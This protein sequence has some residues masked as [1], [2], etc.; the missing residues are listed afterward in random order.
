MNDQGLTEWVVK[1][2][3]GAGF[4]RSRA[5]Q[6]PIRGT[7]RFAACSRRSRRLRS[8]SASFVLPRAI[9]VLLLLLMAFVENRFRNDSSPREYRSGARGFAHL[10]TQRAQSIEGLKLQPFFHNSGGA[11]RTHHRSR[12]HSLFDKG[13]HAP[14]VLDFSP[15]RDDIQSFQSPEGHRISAWSKIKSSFRKKS[16]PRKTMR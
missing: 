10:S 16:W 7:C 4:S 12:S 11:I 8:C 14:L 5:P 15:G 3:V 1:P 9:V 13:H 2:T 6:A